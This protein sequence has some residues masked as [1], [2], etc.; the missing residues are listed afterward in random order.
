MMLFSFRICFIQKSAQNHAISS[1]IYI[2][3][4]TLQGTSHQT[5]PAPNE[6]IGLNNVW[7]YSEK[8]S[9]KVI[10]ILQICILQGKIMENE[11]WQPGPGMEIA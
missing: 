7:T 9:E 11:G 2:F 3:F 4:Q 10:C 6:G 8:E 5:P 1:Y